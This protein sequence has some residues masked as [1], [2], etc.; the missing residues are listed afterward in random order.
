M[1]INILL[2][3][4]FLA[5]KIS[6]RFLMT[7]T[8]V[9]KW[10]HSQ[11]RATSLPRTRSQEEFTWFPT[12]LYLSLFVRK[13][14]SYIKKVPDKCFWSQKKGIAGILLVIQAGLLFSQLMA[15]LKH[16]V[17]PGT[18]RVHSVF[19]QVHKKFF[20]NP[21]KVFYRQITFE[22]YVCKLWFYYWS[23]AKQGIN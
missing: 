22:N 14:L 21:M 4:H 9:L 18:Y 17:L 19:P 7:A 5:E 16:L 8:L 6:E 2:L 11:P 13:N 15:L 20:K 3:K 1:T 23:C 10:P 12:S